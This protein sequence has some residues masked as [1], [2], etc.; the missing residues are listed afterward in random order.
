MIILESLLTTYE[1]SVTYEAAEAVV[2]ISSSL[3]PNHH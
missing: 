2:K 3:K 1:A